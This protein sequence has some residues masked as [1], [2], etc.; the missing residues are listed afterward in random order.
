MAQLV[1]RV[2]TRPWSTNH[3]CVYGLIATCVS[4]S[5]RNTSG[6][7]AQPVMPK[8]QIPNRTNV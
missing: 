6:E 3:Q 8:A 7:P 1:S 2:L 4:T 5:S